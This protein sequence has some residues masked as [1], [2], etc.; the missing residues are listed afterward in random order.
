MGDL[1]GEEI[2]GARRVQDAR[3]TRSTESI[4]QGSEWAHRNGSSSQGACMALTS[5]LCICVK[6]MQLGVLVG[7][8]RVRVGASLALLPVGV[9]LFLLGYLAQVRCGF[10][11]SLRVS[12]CSLFCCYPWEACSFLKGNKRI[13]WEGRGGRMRG[14]WKQRREGKLRSGCTV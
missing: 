12:C 7:L 11:P 3:R 6:V 2:V 9:T 14:N 13:R 5:V 4:K 10:V 8:P 1:V